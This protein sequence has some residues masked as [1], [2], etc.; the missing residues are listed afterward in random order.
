MI[1]VPILF[2]MLKERA[3]RRGTLQRF[4]Y[5]TLTPNPS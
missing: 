5:T 4:S 3:F 2:A 1:L